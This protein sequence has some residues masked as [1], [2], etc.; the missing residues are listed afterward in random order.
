VLAYLRGRP[1]A[2]GEDALARSERLLRESAAA[3]RDGRRDAAQALATAAYLEG[4]EL[5]EP[6]LDAADRPLR[7]AVEKEM[8][9]YRALL[10]GGATTE[11]VDA[12]ARTI[13]ALLDQARARLAPG[14]LP[15][16]AAFGGALLIVLR[17]GLE[18]IL[19]VATI[20]AVLFKAGRRD[21]LP[22][23]HA[24]WVAA[25]A[26][27][28]VTWAAA[29]YVLSLAGATRE[30]TEGAT[31]LVAAGILL[32]VGF[33][34]HGKAYATRRD[35]FVHE[36]LGRALSRRTMW[37]LAALSFLAVYREAF[38]TV[39]FAQALWQHAGPD[40][41][42]AVLGGF[43]VAAVLLAALGWLIVRGGLRLP[44]G[45]FFGVTS[46]ALAA[47]AVV[48]AGKGIAA[49]QEAGIVPVSPI[50]A[51]ALP[52]VG[53]YPSAQ[54]VALQVALLVV[55]AAGFLWTYRSARRT[56]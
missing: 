20:G 34:M 32:Y 39:L 13:A 47:L 31:A 5:V 22:Y 43:G 54:G 30:A 15:P 48:L 26:L 42:G 49:L 6:G 3:Y 37:A 53:L 24:G 41:R 36:R 56:A 17:E 44:L 1:D 25:L 23:I 45:A 19:V 7:M 46:A 51:P 27:G 12:Q 52:L 29:S 33:W 8:G 35:A 18:A 55:V 38:E 40:R 2:V 11:A 21:A 16:L 50:E 4:F 10:R 14:G 28:G 9:G